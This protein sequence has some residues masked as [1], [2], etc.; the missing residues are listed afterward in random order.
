M[1]FVKFIIHIFATILLY[2]LV[3]N[4]LYSRTKQVIINTILFTIISNIDD[5]IKKNN[6]NYACVTSL[7]QQ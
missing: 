6:F 7:S 5:F 3:Y 4:I 1:S 2:L